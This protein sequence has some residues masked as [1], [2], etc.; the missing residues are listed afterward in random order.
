MVVILALVVLELGGELP[1]QLHVIRQGA[2]EEGAYMRA[3]GLGVEGV[4][5]G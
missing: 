5:E 1:Q 3:G 2:R 4:V